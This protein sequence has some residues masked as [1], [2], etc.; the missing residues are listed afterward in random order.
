MFWEELEGLY[1][2]HT[3]K[4]ASCISGLKY[5]GPGGLDKETNIIII[6]FVPIR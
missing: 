1:Y 5:G 3:K 2:V 6:L 4:G